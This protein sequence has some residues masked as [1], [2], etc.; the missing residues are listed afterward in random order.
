MHL[1]EEEW[2]VDDIIAKLYCATEGTLQYSP[3]IL[4]GY[5]YNCQQY[6]LTAVVL[7]TC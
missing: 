1:W 2:L 5:C 6:V 7:Y 4:L 3:R